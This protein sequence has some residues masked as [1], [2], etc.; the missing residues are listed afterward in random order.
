MTAPGAT[1]AAGEATPCDHCGLPVP[2]ALHR[3]G[4]E[5]QFCCEGCRTVFGLLRDTGLDHYYELRDDAA[6]LP[7]RVSQRRF[8]ELDDRALL[9]T[10]QPLAGGLL[11]I[12]VAVCGMHCGACAWLIERLPGWTPGVA[13][14]R[15]D[16]GR[17]TA[18]VT[19]NPGETAL[20]TIARRLDRL[21][22][23]VLPRR[24]D[25]EREA[26]RAIDRRW[27]IRIGVAGALA[28]NVMAIAFALWGDSDGSMDSALRNYFRWIS[29]GL[30][31]TALIWPGRVFFHGALTALRTRTA[32]MDLPIAIGLLAGATSGLV[33]TAMES[34]EV[35]FESVTV[36]VFFLLV[37]RF[38]QHRQQER[39]R[40]S[41]QR[42][43]DLTP[44]IARRLR[45][46]TV[47]DVSVTALEPGDLIEVRPGEVLPADGVLHGSAAT[48]DLAMLTGESKPVAH[49]EGARVNAGAVVIDQA[50]QV[51]VEAVGEATRIGRLMELVSLHA[52]RRTSIVRMADRAAAW[53]VPAV[54]ILA[55]ATVLIWW[56]RAPSL[57]IEH[58]VALLIVTCPC[59]LG[60]ATPLAVVASI[61]RA[62]RCGML[63]KGGDVLEQ[64]AQPGMMVLD[65]TGTLTQGRGSV[66]QWHGDDEA[67]ALAAAVERDVLHPVA[68]ALREGAATG[69]GVSAARNVRVLP[70]R[71]VEGLVGGRSVLVASPRALAE[72]GIEMDGTLAAG[73][74][75]CRAAAHSP[76]VVVVGGAAVAVA[77]IG[78][79]VRDDTVA[80]IKAL[81]QAGWRLSVLSGDDET[82]VRAVAGRVGLDPDHCAG[83]VAPEE[84]AERIAALREAGPVVMVG[85][86]V[87]DAAALAAASVG[88]AVHGGAEASLEAADACLLRPG[89]SPLR[90]LVDGAR[91]TV[92]VI[93]LNLIVSLIYN[94]VGAGLAMAGLIDP[95]VAAV[96]MPLSS[97]TVVTISWR[98]RTFREASA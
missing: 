67:R 93:R 61:G 96:L 34:G 89:L 69:D 22:Y 66:V 26:R 16:L 14:A 50:V 40:D 19:W 56:G 28:G 49:E 23:Q 90:M 29:A 68:R 36:L 59:A 18:V 2:P 9:A 79:E 8:E 78:D 76:V 33:N 47:Q 43:F 71:G 44:R 88:V 15:V 41:V 98:A 85:D 77:G 91:R 58:A 42:L 73:V 81:Q 75:A 48:L 84:K 45:D 3:A 30:M 94:G 27:M 5:Q 57:A 39:A 11:R 24:A 38:V 1:R 10:A 46:G 95:L 20:S 52:S 92:G 21:G 83:G 32:H 51:L 6:A 65:K 60:L 31:L 87:N 4:D 70:G 37:G 7:A 62:A 54:L 63:V 17:G 97:I 53:F 25:G 74:E 13:D 12:E 80:T 64:L 82:I 55:A 35:Y 72:R 86:G